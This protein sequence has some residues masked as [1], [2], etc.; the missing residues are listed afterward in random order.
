MAFVKDKIHP[1]KA[2]VDTTWY[3]LV[4]WKVTKFKTKNLRDPL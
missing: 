4:L 2:Y 1:N 3:H